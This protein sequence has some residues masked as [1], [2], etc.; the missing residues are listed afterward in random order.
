[1]FR[2]ATTRILIATVL[3]T[4][5]GPR[6]R[7]PAAGRPAEWRHIGNSAIDLSLAGLATGPV[8]RVWY[9]GSGSLLIHTASGRVF[10]TADF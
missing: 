8:D 7:R 9:S 6:P 3:G 4:V 10:E 1:M 2:S 5:G